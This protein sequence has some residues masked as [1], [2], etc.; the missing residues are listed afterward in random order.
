MNSLNGQ[1][2]QKPLKAHY[3]LRKASEETDKRLN[4]VFEEQHPCKRDSNCLDKD[5]NKLFSVYQNVKPQPQGN[6]LDNTYHQ[7]DIKPDALLENKEMAPSQYKDG[8]KMSYSE[9]EALK[10]LPEHPSWPKFSGTGE[11]DHM[12]LID[13]IDRLLIDLPTIPDY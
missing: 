4:Q 5:L 7:G 9:R 10:K 2:S 8:A 6:V 13:F 3:Q 12:K 11:Y 1:Y